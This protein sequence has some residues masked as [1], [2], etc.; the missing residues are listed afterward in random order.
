MIKFR[1]LTMIQVTKLQIFAYPGEGINLGV[2]VCN[3]I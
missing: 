3:D 2:S 1:T